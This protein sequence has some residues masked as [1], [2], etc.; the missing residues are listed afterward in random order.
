[1]VGVTAIA[2]TS[3]ARNNA[4]LSALLITSLC[5]SVCV[6]LFQLR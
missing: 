5:L 6:R 2:I 1:V 3:K 4:S